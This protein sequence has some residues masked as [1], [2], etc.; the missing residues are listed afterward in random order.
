MMKRLEK[1]GVVDVFAIAL[2]QP[3]PSVT[4]LI[5]TN[6]PKHYEYN[7]TLYFVQAD[8]LAETVAI[9]VGIKGDDRVSDASGFVI[10]L[11]EFSYSGYTARSL[12]DWLKDAEK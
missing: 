1:Q 6:F 8:D 5:R 2:I 3:N 9:K 10:K 11:Q 12:W 7:Q 4:N